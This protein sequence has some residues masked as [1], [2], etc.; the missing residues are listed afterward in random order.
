MVVLW[1]MNNIVASNIYKDDKNVI[2]KSQTNDKIIEVNNRSLLNRIINSNAHIKIQ[3][4][5]ETICNFI[6]LWEIQLIPKRL[7][8]L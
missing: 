4:P 8:Y 6:E 3:L 7:F 1:T 2:T 5:D